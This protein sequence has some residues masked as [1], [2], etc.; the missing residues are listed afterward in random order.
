MHKG[1]AMTYEERFVSEWELMIPVMS[2]K[3]LKSYAKEVSDT[4]QNQILIW[5]HNRL[6]SEIKNKEILN[7]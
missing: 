3:D 1:V 6:S 2:L 5:L 4:S 7:G